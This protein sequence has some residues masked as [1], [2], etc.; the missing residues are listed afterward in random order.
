MLF[1]VKLEGISENKLWLCDKILLY[2]ITFHER[3]F[4]TTKVSELV[5]DSLSFSITLV[6]VI[7]YSDFS[8]SIKYN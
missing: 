4:V 6:M 8:I 5:I 3:V 2:K 7:L 1:A